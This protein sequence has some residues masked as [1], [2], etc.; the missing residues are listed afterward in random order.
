[1]DEELKRT[2]LYSKHVAAR[3]KLVAFAGWEMPAYYEGIIAEV[4]AVR[5]RVGMFDVSHMGEFI[6]R[7]ARSGEFLQRLTT[8][9]V[10]K[11]YDGRAQY[12]LMLHPDGG[13][14]DDLL[15][16]RYSEDHYMMVVNAANKD[17]DYA[18]ARAN[19][20]PDVDLQ[21]QTMDITLIAVQGPRAVDIIAGLAGDDVRELKYYTF[22]PGRVAG[23]PGTIS[24]TGYTGEDGYELYVANKDAETVWDAVAAA[25][26]EHGLRLCGLGARDCLRLEAGYALYGQ[27]IREDTNPI[28]AGLG[29]VVKMQAGE[30]IGREALVRVKEQGLER[31][32][33]GI[34]MIEKAVPRHGYPVSSE[35]ARVGEVTSG[36]FSPTLDKMIAMAYVRVDRAEPDRVVDVDIRGRRYSG[37]IVPLPFYKRPQ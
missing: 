8:N 22:A 7:G 9:D 24:R 18:W 36:A 31:K 4:R 16:Y 19:L 6:L 15:I 26:A 1:M 23:R 10:G 20:L 11:M 35:G 30:F 14:V 33:V 32:M 34:E 25:G 27:E 17:K 37:R 13:V 21:D 5:T 12:T 28:E 29:W 3:A 2:A